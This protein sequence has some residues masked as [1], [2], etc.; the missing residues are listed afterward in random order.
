MNE[1][2]FTMRGYFDIGSV[3]EDVKAAM[4][5]D[6]CRYPEEYAASKAEGL[7]D[8]EFDRLTDE[9]GQGCPMMVL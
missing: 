3:L 5:N 1:K 2:R 8:E 7:T 9:R 4:R 6:Y